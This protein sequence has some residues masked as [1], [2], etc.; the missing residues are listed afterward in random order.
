M[1]PVDA[2]SI[3]ML[4]VAAVT[5]SKSRACPPAE[6]MVPAL[7]SAMVPLLRLVL[8]RQASL[9]VAEM[10]APALLL[11]VMLPVENV[12]EVSMARVVALIAPELL[13]TTPGAFDPP[14]QVIAVAADSVPPVSIVPTSS[15]LTDLGVVSMTPELTVKLAMGAPPCEKRAAM[16]GMTPLRFRSSVRPAEGIDDRRTFVVLCNSAVTAC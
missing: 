6:V 8:M 12:P 16:K 9:P 7:L 4:A 10:V 2:L 11:T 13:M 1:I 3:W 15:V 5:A 14:V